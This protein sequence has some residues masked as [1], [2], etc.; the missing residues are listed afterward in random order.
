MTSKF[1]PAEEWRFRAAYDAL[2]KEF[3]LA[4][5]MI[6]ARVS[7]T[8]RKSQKSRATGLRDDAQRRNASP[9]RTPPGTCRFYR[10]D[11]QSD[12]FGTRSFIREWGRTGQPGQTRALP[13]APNT[14]H[15]QPLTATTRQGAPGY[16][17]FQPNSRVRSSR[18]EY[19]PTV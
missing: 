7:P 8:R 5:A 9:Q 16:A 6:Q 4:S 11:V 2:D 1:I 15:R 19:L 10:L 17:S 12:L 3:A 13:S 14:R 18:V